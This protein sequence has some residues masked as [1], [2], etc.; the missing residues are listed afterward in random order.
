MSIYIFMPVSAPFLGLL[1][2]CL[3]SWG[4][5]IFLIRQSV[6][7][8]YQMTCT[9]G[10]LE[11]DIAKILYGKKRKE[12]LSLN[13]KEFELVAR[14]KGPKYNDSFKKI[15]TVYKCVRTMEEE[16]VFFIVTNTSEGRTVVYIQLN[17]DMINGLK[18]NIPSKV[19][20]D[21]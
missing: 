17:D 14:L 16:D 8:E 13:C 10:I 3:A 19:F 2:M 18:K 15:P 9:I 20:T 6:E 1:F 7:F 11:L 21:G 12:L 5:Y 4:F